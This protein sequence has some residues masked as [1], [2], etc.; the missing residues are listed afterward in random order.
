MKTTFQ[1]IPN[2]LLYVV[3]C[4]MTGAGLGACGKKNES[5]HSDLP[6]ATVHVQTVEAKTHVAV[7]DVVG[8]VNPKLR[9]VIEAKASG[10]I[11]KMLVAPGQRVKSGELL[12]Q[13]DARESQAKLDQATAVRDQTESDL[14]RYTGLLEKHAITRQ[15][16][17]SVQS[18]ARVAEA[19]VTEAETT[20]GY[21]K[22]TAPFDGV[23]T[24]KLADV[25]DL[26][27]PGK[28]LLE[29]EEPGT[30]RFEAAV[31]E[32]IV[33]R[34]VLGAKLPVR[35]ASSEVVGTVSEIAPAGDTGS[36]T[37]LVQ[38]DLP[39]RYI[40]PARAGLRRYRAR[41]DGTGF[42]RFQKPRR[43]APRE[44]RKTHRR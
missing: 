38:L 1:R 10:R 41:A 6:T 32:A 22:I 12:A 4:V 35:F 21:S 16:F 36:R 8:T 27:V 33:G 13:V 25:G 39:P 14:K 23:I 26:A 43:A 15:E 24:R 3:F 18:K 7:E 34:I 19:A 5:L 42:R 11:E 20:L 17:E 40:R 9:S 31:P 44:N 28:P 29:M 2:P 30:L 37:F